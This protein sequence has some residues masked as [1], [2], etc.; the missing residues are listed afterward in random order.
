MYAKL[1][2]WFKVATPLGSYNPDWAVLMQSEASER[3]YLVVETKGTAFLDGLRGTEAGKIA[4]GQAHFE[5]LEVRDERPTYRVATSV[6]ELLAG[7]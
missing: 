7:V 2:G 5:A 6:E 4:C 1:P 3:L